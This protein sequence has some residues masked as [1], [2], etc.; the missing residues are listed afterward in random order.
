MAHRPW[1]Q[2]TAD[3]DFV[4]GPADETYTVSDIPMLKERIANNPASAAILQAL[5]DRLEAGDFDTPRTGPTETPTG[6]DTTPTGD[7]TTPP[8]AQNQEDINA[9]IAAAMEAAGIGPDFDFSDILTAADAEELF[10][11]TLPIDYETLQKMGAADW[12]PENWTPAVQTMIDKSL[13]NIPDQ[14]YVDQASL[15]EQ[16]GAY[17]SAAEIQQLLEAQGWGAIGDPFGGALS[18]YSTTNAVQQMIKES[19]LQ[20]LSEDDIFTMIQEQFGETMSD[21]DILAAIA[22]AQETQYTSLMDEVQ[23]LIADSL[24]SGMS[25]EEILALIQAEYGDQMSDDDILNAIA[26]AQQGIYDTMMAEVNKLIADALTQGLSPEQIAE[27]I[28]EQFGDQMTDDQIL[29]AIADAQAGVPTIQDIEAMIADALANG[30]SP[31]DIAT[32]ISDYVGDSGLLSADDIATMIADAIAGIGATTGGGALTTESV[33]QM[34]DAAMAQGMSTEQVEAML[35]GS[36]YMGEEGIQGLIGSALEG[37]L[38]QGGSI[39][40]AI[41]AALAA[42]GGGGAGTGTDT[43]TGVPDIDFTNPYTP[44]NFPTSPYGDVDPSDLMF[45]PWYGTTPFAGGTTTGAEDPTGLGNLD[46]GDIANYNFDFL[47]EDEEDLPGLNGG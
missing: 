37:A 20:G 21:E 33:Q 45:N 7:D 34:I 27:M 25:E 31:E 16:L 12:M 40:E 44:G 1:H 35:A 46:L 13:G 32:M 39:S 30:M 8:G 3:E 6:D 42:T 36:G 38:G 28:K 14:N 47:T 43:G 9:A 23:K 24:A 26:T 29:Q 2:Q 18:D 10:K 5:I 4:Y 11:N 22:T 19:L 41:Q 17:P 15:E